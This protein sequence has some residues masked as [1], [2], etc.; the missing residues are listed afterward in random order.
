MEA[1]ITMTDRAAL[2]IREILAVSRPG[3]ALRVKVVGRGGSGLRFQLDLDC[4]RAGDRILEKEGA[5]LLIDPKSSLYLNGM[6]I[7][8]REGLME[9]GLVFNNPH[10]K[11]GC[12][13]GALLADPCDTPDVPNIW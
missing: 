9:A 1:G 3:H 7:D 5:R 12:G 6:E 2:R 8:Y 11:E 4:A 13:C 10:R